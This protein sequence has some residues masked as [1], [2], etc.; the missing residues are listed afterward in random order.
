VRER[1]GERPHFP[2]GAALLLAP[3]L[4]AVLVMPPVREQKRWE[5]MY[6]RA[7]THRWH[8]ISARNLRNAKKAKD[9]GAIQV[10]PDSPP[11]PPPLG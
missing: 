1:G 10:R 3:A 4:L 2:G 11:P 7:D 8:I 9:R 6:S 5:Q